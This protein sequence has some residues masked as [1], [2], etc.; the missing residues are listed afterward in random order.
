MTDEELEEIIGPVGFREYSSAPES[1]QKE[2][3]EFAS[4]L[5]SLTDREFVD[6]AAYRI[7]ESARWAS[8][9]GTYWNGIHAMGSACSVESSR[10]LEAEGH[11]ATCRVTG[12]YVLA[13]NRA[14]RRH[15]HS[16]DTVRPCTCGARRES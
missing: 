7:E 2:V 13:Y 1:Q 9:S 11:A 5:R 8:A 16:P 4:T 14:A 12:L 6:R 15:G 10:R 3:V